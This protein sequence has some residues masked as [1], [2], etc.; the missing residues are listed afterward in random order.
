[1]PSRPPLPTTW[2][3]P[4]PKVFGR[5]VPA[6]TRL[7][8]Q[9]HLSAGLLSVT[10]AALSTVAGDLV[11]VRGLLTQIGDG[12]HSPAGID[13]LAEALAA[14]LVHALRCINGAGYRG[15]SL[16]A[17]GAASVSVIGDDR[18]DLFT[19]PP[20]APL[21]AL[22]PL[23]VLAG[24]IRRDPGAA[25]AALR[26][27]GIYMDTAIAIAGMIDRYAALRAEVA[28]ATGFNDAI[29]A[30]LSEPLRSAVRPDLDPATVIAWGR[31][32]RPQLAA[33]RAAIANQA[34]KVLL[35]VL[36]EP[37]PPPTPSSER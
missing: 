16:I 15:R 33:A 22:S 21:D 3:Q 19:L 11:A 26:P 10:L 29:A 8:Q 2:S 6:I 24:H 18:S 14:R 25:A 12:G 9:L 5:T 30:S 17:D 13:A 35:G 7:N 28:A 4:L 27:D 34:P 32:V 31:V 36:A 23:G 20:S 37:G 1:M